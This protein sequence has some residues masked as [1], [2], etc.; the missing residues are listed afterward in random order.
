MSL[1]PEHAINNLC[2]VAL[3]LLCAFLTASEHFSL[4]QTNIRADCSGETQVNR[5]TW[6]FNLHSW[7][8]FGAWTGLQPWFVL[9]LH[10]V[11]LTQLCT[12]I[13]CLQGGREGGRSVCE[14]KPWGWLL[15]SQCCY[16]PVCG[17]SLIHWGCS[18]FNRYSSLISHFYWWARE[19]FSA[20]HIK[21]TKF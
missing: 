16:K 3:S 14:W 10:P 21:N 4:S 11:V 15:S 19:R 8:Q 7:I 17:C 2:T 13:F 6:I 18:Y 1:H 5:T 20:I 9:V 12:V